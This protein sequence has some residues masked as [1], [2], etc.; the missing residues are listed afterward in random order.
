MRSVTPDS[1]PMLGDYDGSRRNNFTALRIF[2]AWCVLFGH[3]FPITGHGE[4]NPLREFFEK[5]TWIGE[6]A[7]SGFFA[8]SGF[9]VTASFARRGLLDYCISR[10]LR[11]YPALIVCVCLTTVVLGAW[12]TT[13]ERA[14]YFTNPRTWNYLWNTTALFPM[15]FRLPGVFESLPRPG[16]NGSLWTLPVEVSCYILLMVVGATGLLRWRTL[17][18]LAAL[19][20]LLFAFNYFGDIPLVGRIEKWAEPCVYFLLGVVCYLNRAAIPLSLPLGVAAAALA[21]VALGKPWFDFVFPPAFVYLIF[22]LA[23]RSPFL[24]IDRWF[25]DP[26]YGIY[27]YAWPV[28]QVIVYLFPQQGPY[29]NT[30]LATLVVVTLAL[31]SWHFL[32][33]P[34]LGL[35]RRWLKTSPEG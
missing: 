18:N 13:L 3:S 7:V 32:E 23:Y 19:A 14:D 15:S 12:L 11:I 27:I 24:D 8:I 25:G 26:S 2:F 22:F 1:T 20:L 29:F 31:L 6:I 33:K 16:V 10:V 21:Y 34:A 9:L 4:L 17:G 35:K 30:A 28:Q 5:S